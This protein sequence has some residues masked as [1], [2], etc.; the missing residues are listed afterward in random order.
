MKKACY[1]ILNRPYSAQE[2]HRLKAR[3]IEHMTNS[4]EWGEFFPMQL[5]PFC[6]N[7]SVAQQY[8]PLSRD[9]VSE[10]GLRWREE[11]NS[12]FEGTRAFS[13]PERIE[14]TPESIVKQALV[15]TQSNK[16][17]KLSAPE[18]TLYRKLKVPLPQL[19]PEDRYQRRAALRNPRRLYA[20]E[21]AKCKTSIQTSC[22]PER[23]EIVLCEDCY[24]KEA[25]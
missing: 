3:V 9:E 17:F 11:E 13:I 4:G 7:E 23:S 19:G 8:F 18:L 2:Y 21:C 6:Y 1:C 5:S 16:P 22:G 25:N 20:R 12:E 15:C 24:Q 10:R 14:D